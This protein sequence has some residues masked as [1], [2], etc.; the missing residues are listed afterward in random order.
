MI[1]FVV[2]LS[3]YFL[4]D[5]KYD[6]TMAVTPRSYK[7]SH[8][9]LLCR[10]RKSGHK[11]NLCLKSGTSSRFRY[12]SAISGPVFSSSSVC[13]AS[14]DVSRLRHNCIPRSFTIK[15]ATTSEVI[16]SDNIPN[17]LHSEDS[18]RSCTCIHTYIQA[19]L[20][21]SSRPSPH[22]RSECTD[23]VWNITRYHFYL[24]IIE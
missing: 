16:T 1:N 6:K 14:Q 8:W 10:M 9:S 5:W 3:I 15:Y 20:P 13:W 22:W 19:W 12:K 11:Q 17:T 21:L 18:A 23:K 2:A 24:F 4:V 7:V